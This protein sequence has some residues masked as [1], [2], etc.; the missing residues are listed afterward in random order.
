MSNYVTKSL[1]NIDQNK[2]NLKIILKKS[3]CLRITPQPPI[4][5]YTAGAAGGRM[6]C[7]N[8]LDFD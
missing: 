3:R 5:T 8:S 7:S 4:V 6:N 2:Y 1:N